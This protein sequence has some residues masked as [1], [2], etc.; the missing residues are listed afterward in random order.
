MVPKHNNRHYVSFC[1]KN[2]AHFVGSTTNETV[3]HRMNA[4]MLVILLLYA[5]HKVLEASLLGSL[6]DTHGKRRVD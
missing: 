6:C 5:R 1:D 4:I 3:Q 2:L